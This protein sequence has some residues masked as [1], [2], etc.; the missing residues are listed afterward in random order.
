M[1]NITLPNDQ[2]ITPETLKSLGRYDFPDPTSIDPEGIGLVAMGGDLASDTLISAYAQ[3]LFPWFNEDEPIAWWCPEPRCVVVPSDY[4]PSKSLR[5]QARRERWQLTLNQA[6]DDVIRACSL[7]RSDGLPEGE[8]TWIHEEMIEA[9]TNLHAQGFAH[10]IEVWNDQGQLIGGLYGLKLGGI[11]FGESMF[12]Y[13]SNASKLAFWGLMRLCE[14]SQV[15]LVDCQLPND[16]LMSLGATTVPRAEFLTQ[17]DT[18]IRAGS[19]KWQ[20]DAYIPL[21]VSLLDTP[22]PWQRKL[23]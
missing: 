1:G 2:N 5:K 21:P 10:S 9:Y 13:V 6:F 15:A 8:H 14:Q 17:L 19:V 7:P 3:G 20:K 18:L 22:T 11:Y 23:S 12:H 4:Q 16:H